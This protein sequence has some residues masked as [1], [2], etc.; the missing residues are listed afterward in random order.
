MGLGVNFRGEQTPI[1]NPGWTVDS[2]VTAELMAE[3]KINDRYNLKGNVSNFTNKLY[4]D[5]LYS[6]HYVPGAGR[7]V[8]VT[9]NAKF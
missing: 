6:G 5:A 7:T 9:L 8:Q 3:Y 4:A 1:R 2:Y